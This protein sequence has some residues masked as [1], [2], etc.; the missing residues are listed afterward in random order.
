MEIDRLPRYT[1]GPRNLRHRDMRIASFRDEVQEDDL[2]AA[3]HLSI[4]ARTGPTDPRRQGDQHG[5]RER[6]R[7]LGQ[8][9]NGA[10]N[11]VVA[12]FEAQALATAAERDRQTRDGRFLGP[13]HAV[14]V[15]IK[16]R[17]W[18][19]GKESTINA[20]MHKDFVAPEDAV[21]VDRIRKSGAVPLREICMRNHLIC[22]WGSSRTSWRRARSGSSARSSSAT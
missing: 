22:G 17:F 7:G 15:T 8:G 16:E 3:I 11:A 20:T 2:H 9:R 13:L 6:A 4:S 12:L 21:I 5:H 19:Q 18:I 14:P 10:L 1:S